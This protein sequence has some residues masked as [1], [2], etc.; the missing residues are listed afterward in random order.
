MHK[1]I[2]I[3]SHCAFLA[4]LLQT[5]YHTVNGLKYGAK[6]PHRDLT[7]SPTHIILR[8]N[9]S[10][11]QVEIDKL[12]RE[13]ADAL[14]ALYCSSESEIPEVLRIARQNISGRYHLGIDEALHNL[15]NGPYHLIKPKIAELIM[16]SLK[17][18]AEENR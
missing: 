3:V 15:S 4:I 10:I 18:S 11:P 2:Q 6:V 9:G 14:N 12:K 16:T 8:L 13:R 1:L 7:Q 17:W 5:M